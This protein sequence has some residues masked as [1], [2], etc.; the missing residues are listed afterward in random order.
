LGYIPSFRVSLLLLPMS[1]SAFSC[2]LPSL[3]RLRSHYALVPL[4]WRSPLDMSKPSQLVL[5]KLFFRL[6][7]VH[8]LAYHVSYC[9]GLDPFLYGHKFNATYTFHN[10]YLLNMMSFLG[11]H[12][13][14]YNIA[15]LIVVL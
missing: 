8:I 12:S 6:Q 14:P 1:S 5:D 2:L 13:A 4:V 15:G 7:L 3:L 9:F 11:Q 10:T